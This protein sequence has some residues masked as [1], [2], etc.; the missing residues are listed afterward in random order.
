MRKLLTI[1]LIT[2]A[3]NSNAQRLVTGV[4][5][6]S[7]TNNPLPFANIITNTAKGTITDMEGKFEIK[8]SNNVTTLT[9]S[10]IGYASSTI[11]LTNNKNFYTVTLN[12]NV[13]KLNEVTLVG[14]ENPALR[15]IRNTIKNKSTNNPEKVLSSYNYK[16]YN[17]LL[18]T[19]NPDSIDSKIDSLFKKKKNGKIEFLRVDS[20]NYELKK[21]LS[22]THLYMTEKVSDYAFTKAKGRRETIL[23]TRM[24]GL[25]EPLYEAL[26]LQIQ[27]FSFYE[28]TY[29]LFGT[30]YTNPIANNA[31]QKYNYRILDTISGER[32][33]F[34]IYYFPKKK[35]EVAGLEGVLYIDTKTYAL[36]KAIAQ[37]KAVV[38]VKATQHFKYYTKEGVWFPTD[39]V[40]SIEKGKNNEALTLFGG[41]VNISEGR[42]DSTVVRTNPQDGSEL[43]KL[44][45]T[46]KA[47]DIELNKPLQIKKR[48]LAIEIDDY[49]H[50]RDQDFWNKYRTDS[51]TNRGKETY[52]FLDSIADAEKVDK[53]INLARKLLTGY[54]PTKYFDIDARN[55]IKYNNHE[56]FRLGVGAITN[57]N[58]SP[59]YKLSGYSVF[60]TLDKEFKFGLGAAARLDK[61][62]TTWAGINYKDDL[63]ET[64]SSTIITDGRKFSLFEPRLFNITSFYHSREISAYIEHDITAKTH[65]ELELKRSNVAPTFN[66]LF[67]NS[68]NTYNTYTLTTATLAIDWSPF[69]EYMITRHGKQ[70]LKTGYPQFAL[71]ATQSFN[72]L[73]D[74]DF[75]F[76]K[77][78]FR[79][80]YQF[81]PLNKAFTTSFLMTGGIAFGDVPLTHLLHASPN[82]SSRETFLK[83]FSIAGRDSFETMFF[84]EFYSDKL[85]TFQVKH[86]FKKFN[87]SRRFKPELILISRYAIGD[88]KDT[89]EHLNVTFNTLKHGY[90]ESGLEINRLFAGFGLSGM[91]RHGAYNLPNFEDNISFKF[92]FYFSLGF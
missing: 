28:S 85:A 58:F 56:G 71:Q 86:A 39:K 61:N 46:E 49:A 9:F 12:E 27:S 30:Q 13:E 18:V 19:A 70:M 65:A 64:G 16:A 53:K 84:N 25:K 33:S 26:A 83:R 73:F 82:Q 74:G 6:D 69:N 80:Q 3:F 92:T 31:L 29:T 79:A 50:S 1:L 66:Y 63:V 52:V 51:L 91:Y 88:V 45:S 35:G 62:T 14:G 23:A 21:Q 67:N 10:Y 34:M 7:K 11:N 78:N 87:I 59:I 55:F 44:I 15:I 24:A 60:G 48:G 41:T 72:N 38:D 4:V 57:A 77:L 2:I 81:Q 42:T 37:I 8:V 36:Q 40:V 20:S 22:K 54:I 75:N 5:K 43:I 90:M 89:Q 32:P 68:G 17:K 47:F 76:T